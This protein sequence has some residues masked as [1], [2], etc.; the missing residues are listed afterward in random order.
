MYRI[1]HS[2]NLPWKKR[3]KKTLLLRWSSTV[4]W[5][6]LRSSFTLKRRMCWVKPFSHWPPATVWLQLLLTAVT[7]E[8]IWRTPSPCWFLQRLVFRKRFCEV[9]REKHL[10]NVRD[11]KIEEKYQRFTQKRRTA[12]LKAK[13]MVVYELLANGNAFIFYSH[14]LTFAKE[15]NHACSQ[16]CIFTKPPGIQCPRESSTNSQTSFP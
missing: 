9:F 2:D 3:T 6:S 4:G 11:T 5:V 12:V 10:I 1:L 8:S 14:T 7:S 13:L 15:I 16:P